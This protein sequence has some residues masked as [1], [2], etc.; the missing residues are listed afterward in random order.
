MENDR[1]IDRYFES[2]SILL[3][4]KHTEKRNINTL[5]TYLEMLHSTG[6]KLKDKY[7]CN[8][9]LANSHKQPTI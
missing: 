5:I 4:I 8:E 3:K 9:P 2:E 6:D 7:Q 1:F